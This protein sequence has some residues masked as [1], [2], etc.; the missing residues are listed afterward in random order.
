MQVHYD[1]LSVTEKNEVK[2]LFLAQNGIIN[3]DK[4]RGKRFFCIPSLI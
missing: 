1:I 3:E 4:S 2:L